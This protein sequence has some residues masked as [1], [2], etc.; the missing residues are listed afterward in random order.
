MASRLSD[1][2]IQG[3]PPPPIHRGWGGDGPSDGPGASRRASF[4]LLVLLVIATTVVFLAFIAALLMRRSI[5]SD[6]VS[7]PKP[8]VLWWNTA[9]LL[10]SSGCLE[11]A[12]RTLRAGNRSQF[13]LW[14]TIATGLGVLFLLGQALAW[15]QLK[16][17]GLYIASNPS[18]SF[19][20]ILTAAHA[21]HLLGGITALIYVDVQALR[22]SLGPGKRTAVDMSAIFWHF[23]DGLWLLLMAVFYVWG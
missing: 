3:P 16:A 11:K 10:A 8:L 12:R 13:N 17:E 15:R 19:F 7:T 14:W 2:T 20:Y 6:W 1:D 23:L 22:F 5:A 9:V 21:A 18:T 4:I